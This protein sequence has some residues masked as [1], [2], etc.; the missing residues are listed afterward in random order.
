MDIIRPVTLD[1]SAVTSTSVAVSSK[2]EWVVSTAYTIGNTV[3]VST[4]KSGSTSDVVHHEYEALDS[5]T[6]DYPPDDINAAVPKWLDLGAENSWKMFDGGVATQTVDVANIQVVLEPGGINAVGL[7]NVGGA[8]ISVTIEDSGLVVFSETRSLTVN[9]GVLDWYDYFFEPIV[10]KTDIVFTG[11]PCYGSGVVT[12]SIDG[13][14]GEAV[15]CGLVVVGLT[16]YLGMTLWGVK[17][18]ITDYSVK[19]VNDFGDAVWTRRGNSRRL[20]TDLYVKTEY[21]DETFRTLVEYT[22]TPLLW[23]LSE[24]LSC[25]LAYGVFKD[26]Q[27]VIQHIKGASCALEIEGLM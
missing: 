24:L 27:I 1:N 4:K 5:T 2:A 23:I 6:G 26:F 8:S 10:R 21:I 17:P 15:A 14:A 20:E 13:E 3:K 11:L 22:A 18:G 16:K 12:I 25:T 19:T 9:D 7:L